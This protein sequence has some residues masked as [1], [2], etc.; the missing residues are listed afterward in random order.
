MMGDLLRDPGCHLDEKSGPHRSISV[1]VCVC[2]CVG[3]RAFVAA[4]SI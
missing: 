1:S 3:G 4:I 2:V